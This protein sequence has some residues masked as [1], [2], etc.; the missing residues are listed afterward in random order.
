MTSRETRVCAEGVMTK[1]FGGDVRL[2]EGRRL[3]G[4]NNVMRFRVLDG[5]NRAPATV[6]TKRPRGNRS[7]DPD[8]ITGPDKLTGSVRGFYSDWTGGRFLTEIKS[9]SIGA[10]RFYGGDLRANLIAIEDLGDVTGS[11]RA[12]HLLLGTDPVAAERALVSLWRALGGLHAETIGRKSLFDRIRRSL[13]PIDRSPPQREYHRWMVDQWLEICDLTGVQ[14]RRGFKSDLAKVARFFV[15]PGPFLAF[16]HGDACPGNDLFR[17][18]RWGWLDMENTG[19]RNALLDGMAPRMYYPTCWCVRRIP[20]GTLRKM[21]SAYRKALVTGCPEAG[22]ER[23]WC[24]A[25]TEACAHWA[26]IGTKII[27]SP[28]ELLGR[29]RSRWQKI[30]KIQA[31]DPWHGVMALRRS[32]LCRMKMFA[33]IAEEHDHLPALGEMAAD[34]ARRWAARWPAET[35]EMPLYRAFGGPEVEPI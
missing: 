9:R 15:N 7:F 1:T 28:A 31:G 8:Q 27:T 2:G 30:L 21:E 33:E 12:D 29:G 14:P 17:R 22:D 19:Y 5:P 24:Q 10:P 25:R 18:G 34:V 26:E 4:Q 20:E 6:V 23:L 3:E 11:I 13:G 32:N 35:H 16:N